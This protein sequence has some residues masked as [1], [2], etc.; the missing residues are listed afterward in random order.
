MFFNK[1]DRLQMN[2]GI[3]LGSYL[4]ISL[5]IRGIENGF[6][7]EMSLLNF[8]WLQETE[9]LDLGKNKSEGGL[10]S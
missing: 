4:E 10:L 9:S 8:F 2:K 1:Y 7:E 6:T 3:K 5:S